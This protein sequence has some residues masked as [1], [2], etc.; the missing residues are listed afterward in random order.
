M[1]STTSQALVALL[2]T[3]AAAAGVARAQSVAAVESGA[4]R[5]LDA[6]EV[7]QVPDGETPLP[8]TLWRNSDAAAVGPLMAKLP[9]P[10]P[11]PAA[12]RLA[13]AAL[14]SPAAAPPAGSE[15]AAND[16]AAK[17]FAALGR[18]GAADEIAA[19]ATLAPAATA[20]PN[21]ITYAAQADLARGRAA[22]ACKRMQGVQTNP[23][24]ILRLR[25]FCFAIAGQQGGA[26]L[27]AEVARA[28]GVNDFWLF[29]ALPAVYGDGAGPAARFDSSLNA[30][31]SIAGKLKLGAKPLLG[32]S[33]LALDVV[34]R[35]QEAAPA[36]RAAAAQTALARYAISPGAAREALAAAT[37]LKSTKASPLPPLTLALATVAAAK[38]PAARALAIETALRRAPSWADYVAAA[39]LVKVD[40]D[41]LPHNATTAN[42]AATLARACIAAGDIRGAAAWRDLIALAGKGPGEP[43]R[44]ALDVA[45]AAGGT[46]HQ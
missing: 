25:A 10:F 46:A 22:D 11:S 14:M 20:D 29:S 19:M 23:Q 36:L 6:W 15:I 38:D 18:F 8:A 41:A 24:F 12:T 33:L 7:G 34:V 44:A 28:A 16:A 13:R 32:A 21:I 9:G 2:L 31:V 3:G 45:I 5:A 30:S 26:D 43:Y 4:L 35:T 27:A 17:R 39:R 40:I 42:A 37:K 1:R